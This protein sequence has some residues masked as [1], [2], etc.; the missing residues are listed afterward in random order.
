MGR[1]TNK[2]RFIKSI[3]NEIEQSTDTE[4]KDIYICLLKEKLDAYNNDYKTLMY[5]QIYS[6]LESLY[7]IMDKLDI[8]DEED[9]TFVIDNIKAILGQQYW[10]QYKDTLLK[11]ELVYEGN[12]QQQVI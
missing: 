3:F 8:K 11:E 12:I 9:H 7:D 4:L 10:T 2:E 6:T 1:P 5:D